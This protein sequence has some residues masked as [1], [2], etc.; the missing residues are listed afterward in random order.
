MSQI[1]YADPDEQIIA[2]ALVA[3]I[4]SDGAI[5]T[6]H[7]NPACEICISESIRR[8]RTCAFIALVW[9]ENFRAYS[10]RSFENGVWCATPLLSSLA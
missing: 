8:A 7:G 1:E 10:S 2:D 3:N 4:A 5:Y 6:S 9:A